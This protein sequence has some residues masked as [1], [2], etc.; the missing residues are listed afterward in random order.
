MLLL[1]VNGR[2]FVAGFQPQGLSGL[3]R[4]WGEEIPDAL[5]VDPSG[6]I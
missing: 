5:H 4:T 6:Q 2:S 3:L 1:E